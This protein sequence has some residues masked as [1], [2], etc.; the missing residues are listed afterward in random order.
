MRDTVAEVF[1]A[2]R[3]LTA[4]LD[5]LDGV[6][7]VYFCHCGAKTYVEAAWQDELR[8]LHGALLAHET[9]SLAKENASCKE[10]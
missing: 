9:I 3:E 7:G 10:K 6:Y 2:A 8:R 1:A 5:R 4:A